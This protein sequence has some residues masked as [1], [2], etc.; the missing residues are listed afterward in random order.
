MELGLEG[1]TAVITGGNSGIG[2]GL[3]REFAREGCNVVIAARDVEKSREVA[4]QAEHQGGTAMAIQTDITDRESVDAMVSK[5]VD[6]SDTR[7]KPDLLDTSGG[8]SLKR[9]STS[10]ASGELPKA[11]TAWRK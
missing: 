9:F 1:R 3:S 11:S 2:V 6:R 10:S 5:T 4:E 8:I 7:S